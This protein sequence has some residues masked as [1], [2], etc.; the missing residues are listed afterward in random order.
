MHHWPSRA[1]QSIIYVEQQTGGPK[2]TGTLGPLTCLSPPLTSKLREEKRLPKGIRRNYP[3]GFNSYGYLAPWSCYT[4]TFLGLQYTVECHVLMRNNQKDESRHE[5]KSKQETI[6]EMRTEH[7][8]TTEPLQGHPSLVKQ[9]AEQIKH[10][11]LL[12]L[13]YEVSV[14]DL[15]NKCDS[16]WGSVENETRVSFVKPSLRT[17]NS[18]AHIWLFTSFLSYIS[19]WKMSL[20]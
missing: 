9:L 15:W 4:P 13:G 5:G 14:C 8:G 20:F 10:F 12:D 19:L 6:G 7:Q 3:R 17:S 1:S 18:L 16:P 11:W 2:D